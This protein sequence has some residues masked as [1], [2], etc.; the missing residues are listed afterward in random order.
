MIWELSGKNIIFINK[1]D[2]MRVQVISSVTSIRIITKSTYNSGYFLS[3][4]CEP[5]LFIPG[6]TSFLDWASGSHADTR[7]LSNPMLPCSLWMAAKSGLGALVGCMPL[8]LCR[9]C[10][11]QTSFV[12][13]DPAPTVQQ[14]AREPGSS[15]PL[16]F[17]SHLRGRVQLGGHSCANG[18]RKLVRFLSD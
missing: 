2:I 14:L 10:L 1:D 6:L 13:S 3:W 9:P 12:Q 18:S 5:W 8:L 11:L 16:I 7:D 15:L 4:S 17:H